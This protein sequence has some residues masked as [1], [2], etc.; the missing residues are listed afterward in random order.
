MAHRLATAARAE[1][2]LVLDAGRVVEQGSHT[3]LL[4][5]GGHYARPWSADE[6]TVP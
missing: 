1:R 6:P 5:P 3:A 2:I 4:A